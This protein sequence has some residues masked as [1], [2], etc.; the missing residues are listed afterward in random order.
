MRSF[1]SSGA[2]QALALLL[3]LLPTGPTRAE[4]QTS[5]VEDILAVL[6]DQGLI[7]EAT[8]A[9]ILA[10]HDAQAAKL[11]PVASALLDG[12]DF[13]GDFR[14]RHEA[15]RFDEDPTGS[16]ATNRYRLRYRARFGARKRINDWLGL[17]FRL[18]SGGSNARSAN[19]TL[20]RGNDFD[21]D[22]IRFDQ[23][24]M[25]ITPDLGDATRLTLEGGKLA[26]P[27][28]W[29]VGKDY[30][31]WDFDITLEGA[32]LRLEHQLSERAR[33]FANA[34]YYVARENT[35]SAD[36]KL[37]PVQLG[38][39][40]DV[41][42]SV[43]L[44]LRGTAYLWHALGPNFVATAVASGNLPTAFDDGTA[45]IGTGSAYLRLGQLE[46]WPVTLWGTLGRNFSAESGLVVA[47]IPTPTGKEDTA[48]VAGIEAGDKRRFVKLGLLHYYIEAN[49]LLG[50]FIDMDPTDGITNR[51]AWVAYAIRQ[52]SPNF[53]FV[54]TLMRDRAINKDGAFTGCV[55]TSGGGSG[56]GPFEVS[57][58]DSERWRIQTDLIVR[59]D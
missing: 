41:A 11:A 44:G 57:V 1:I 27:Y 4:E 38:G 40:F 43:E 30:L 51:R 50:Q 35:S 3:L 45:T 5:S 24:W 28:R 36:P 10:K 33:L 56:C 58:P 16:T 31:V 34:G 17:G 52:L 59:F 55:P 20:G 42:D 6:A 29:N 14:L 49:A 48:W 22:D 25:A 21:S 18:T 9:R 46:D 32:G 7:D 8:H 19:Q 37:I 2:G 26:N 53:D 12:W 23:A 54:L 15:F 47:P 39:V 13:K